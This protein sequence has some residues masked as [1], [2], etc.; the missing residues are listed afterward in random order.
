MVVNVRR[1]TRVLRRGLWLIILATLIGG[2]LGA[3]VGT[4]TRRSSELSNQRSY[5]EAVYRLGF[6][7]V[8]AGQAPSTQLAR[9]PAIAE[10]T[11]DPK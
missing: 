4:L 6:D 10:L 7:P 2:V 1:S 9:L 11:N 3:T 5:F 8:S